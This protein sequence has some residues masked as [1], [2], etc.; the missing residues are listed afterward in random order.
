MKNVLWQIKRNKVQRGVTYEWVNK[1]TSTEKYRMKELVIHITVKRIEFYL[2]FFLV[3][4]FYY[5][6]CSVGWTETK[7]FFTC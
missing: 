3:P 4:T 5:F 2:F 6:Y 7:V 1:Q